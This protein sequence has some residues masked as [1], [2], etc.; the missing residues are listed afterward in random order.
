MVQQ[1]FEGY[2]LPTSCWP[3]FH[4][5]ADKGK[6]QG[7]SVLFQLSEKEKK[8]GYSNAKSE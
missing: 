1:L 5:S 6:S 7:K 2:G 4:L 3:Q 8:T